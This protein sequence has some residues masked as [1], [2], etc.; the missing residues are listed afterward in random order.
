M[1]G[2]ALRGNLGRLTAPRRCR[3]AIRGTGGVGD[4]LGFGGEPG[5][6]GMGEHVIQR[7]E[8]TEGQVRISAQDLDALAGARRRPAR[9]RDRRPPPGP[10]PR[11]GGGT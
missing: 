10:S 1:E 4:L 9:P 8:A 2:S 5:Q 3:D 11:C 7:Q 6:L